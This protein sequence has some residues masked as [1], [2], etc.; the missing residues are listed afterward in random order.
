MT[1]R[2]YTALCPDKILQKYFQ[3]CL[4]TRISGSL[5]ASG[6]GFCFADIPLGRRCLSQAMLGAMLVS[7]VNLGGLRSQAWNEY[8]ILKAFHDVFCVIPKHS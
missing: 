3:G 1:G 5:C 6:N 7:L 8:Y 2:C 4:R